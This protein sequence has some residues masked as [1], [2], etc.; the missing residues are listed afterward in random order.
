MTIIHVPN[1]NIIAPKDPMEAGSHMAGW[2]KIEKLKVG[3]DGVPIEASRTLAADW[4]PNIITN[5]G[6]NRIGTGQWLNACH[7]GSGAATPQF[8][9]TGLQSFLAGTTVVNDSTLSAQGAPPY[10]GLRRNT[11]RF[12]AGIAT[13]NISEVGVGWAST[14]SVL[15]SRAL[16]LD[17][18]LN[19]TTITVLADEVLD[20]TYEIR[21]YPPDSD[22][23]SNITITGVGTVSVTARAASVTVGGLWAPVQAG[24]LGGF[25]ATAGTAYSGLIGGVTGSPAG[26]SS[27]SLS[28]ANNAYANNSYQ[29]SGV[30]TYGLNNG[31]VGGIKSILCGLGQGSG[32]LGSMQFEF[33]TAI[34]KTAA[35]TLTITVNHT[36]A[37]RP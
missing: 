36:W 7:V 2:Y 35:Q 22:V 3:A 26:T 17:G 31:N 12:N 29:R 19:P 18:G 6:L 15:F 25:P 8:T 20:V 34:N 14:G 11:Y 33:D 24:T 30:I 32:G 1:R 23:V 16:I 27:S 37:R 9:D 13:G 10:Y 4:F 21:A 5:Q 28:V